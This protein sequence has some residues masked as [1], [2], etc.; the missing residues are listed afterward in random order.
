MMKIFGLKVE[1]ISLDDLEGVGVPKN[2]LRHF[3]G[4]ARVARQFSPLDFRWLF[5]WVIVAK[6]LLNLYVT[7]V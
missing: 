4:I 3:T 1:H 6:V 5:F 2:D 7:H